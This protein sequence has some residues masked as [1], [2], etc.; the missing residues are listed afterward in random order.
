M[1]IWLEFLL[2]SLIIIICGTKLSK[3][4]DILAEKTEIGGAWIGLILMASITSLPELTTGISSV[5]I[6]DAPDI[7]LGDIMGACVLNLIILALLDLL[8]ESSPL[9]SKVGQSHLLSAGFG[10]VLIGIASL[11]IL[12]KDMMPVIGTIGIYTP[13]LFIVYMVGIRAVYF[14]EKR[15]IKEFA[16]EA[17]KIYKHISTPKAV[18]MYSLNAL[19]IIMVATAL[20]FV[21]A[22]L[23]E[24]SGLGSNFVG[25]VFVAMATTLPE[26]V[27]SV[28]AMRIGAY[29]LAIGNLFGSNMFN[30]SLLGLNDIFYTKG[31]L[32]ADI[33]EAHAITG[34]MA[35]IMTAI[36]VLGLTYR[37]QK[38]ILLRFGWDSLAIFALGVVNMYFVYTIRNHL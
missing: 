37:P 33:S 9:F 14:Y 10:V 32:L 24:Q 23:S 29:D 3:Y 38:R 36:A 7:A 17:E 15:A 18:L 6:A 8:D 27:V 35:I 13:L 28:S 31:S 34:I 30:I 19:I 21:A 12:I 1:L 20:P 25:T 16:E 4:G 2:L 22:R 26:L 11:S 5:T